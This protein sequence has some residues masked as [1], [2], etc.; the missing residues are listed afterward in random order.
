M[1]VPPITYRAKDGI[2]LLPAVDNW[3]E[4]GDKESTPQP[5]DGDN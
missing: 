5:D 1:T 3:E 2:E 4:G